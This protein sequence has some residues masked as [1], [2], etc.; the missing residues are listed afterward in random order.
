MLIET[1][2]QSE[3]PKTNPKKF[4]Q[5]LVVALLQQA[6][7]PDH[8]NHSRWTA[9]ILCWRAIPSCEGHGAMYEKC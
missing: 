2:N 6:I 9:R 5:T 4:D 7:Q 3:P 8:E 1:G